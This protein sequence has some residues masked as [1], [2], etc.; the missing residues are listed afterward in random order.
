[1]DQLAQK[2]KEIDRLR[3]ALMNQLQKTRDLQFNLKLIEYCIYLN[4]WTPFLKCEFYIENMEDAHRFLKQY[5]YD[6]AVSDN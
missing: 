5:K 6:P 4:S 2:Q 3:A 1:M